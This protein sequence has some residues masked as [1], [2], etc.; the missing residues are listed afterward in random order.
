MVILNEGLMMSVLLGL[1]LTGGVTHLVT[2]DES[3]CD[4]TLKVVDAAANL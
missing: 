2:A 1:L 3:D 4:T